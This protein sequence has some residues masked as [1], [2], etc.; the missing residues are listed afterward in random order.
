MDRIT[1]AGILIPIVLLAAAFSVRT[2]HATSPRESAVQAVDSLI[3]RYWNPALSMFN[4]ADPCNDC[5]RV[6]H[7]WW[8][9]HAIDALLDGYVLTGDPKYLDV[10]EQ[11]CRGAQ[12]QRRHFSTITTMTCSDG[13]GAAALTRLRGKTAT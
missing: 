12:A 4:T 7:Y 5:N 1:V 8:Q 9:A 11:L 13:P 6:F 2:A 10:M 3:D